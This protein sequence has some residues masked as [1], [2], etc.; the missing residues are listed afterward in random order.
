MFS[1]AF[2]APISP[3]LSIISGDIEKLPYCEQIRPITAEVQR[4]VEVAKGDWDSMETSWDFLADAIVGAANGC[5]PMCIA[6]A[7]LRRR[8][9]DDVKELRSIEQHINESLSEDY[10][11]KTEVDCDVSLKDITLIC[12]PLN[13]YGCDKPDSELRPF[14]SPT[15]CGSS[16]VM[17]WAACSAVIRWT[18][19]A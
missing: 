13:R 8:Q 7:T 1:S 6:Y 2:L 18:N 3:S 4:A 9:Q 14:F 16:S 12:N 11:L 19:R 15:R 5:F 17:R 10:K